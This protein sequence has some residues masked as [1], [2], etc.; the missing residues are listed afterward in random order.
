MIDVKCKGCVGFVVY[1]FV[2]CFAFSSHAVV[3][4]RGQGRASLTGREQSPC[5]SLCLWGMCGPWEGSSVLANLPLPWNTCGLIHQ[6]GGCISVL[7]LVTV[8]LWHSLITYFWSYVS[9]S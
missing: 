4:S 8:E 5:L 1:F 6:S 9:K 2:F 3:Y 7:H